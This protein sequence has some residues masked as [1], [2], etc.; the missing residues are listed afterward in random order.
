MEAELL[1][2]D[3]SADE[4]CAGSATAL[5]SVQKKSLGQKAYDRLLD[6]IITSE[7][8]A[9]SVLQDRA[10]SNLLNIS[11]TPARE[12][13][14]RLESEGFLARS[15]GRVL[16]VKEISVRDLIEILHIRRVLETESVTLATGRISPEILDSVAESIHA[17]LAKSHPTV[18]ED[19]TVDDRFHG[20]V[21]HHSGNSALAKM[22]QDL[23]MKTR[24]F[25]I[26]RV[27]E[28]FILGNREHLAMIE[29]LRRKDLD[30]ARAQ[31]QEHLDHVKESIVSKLCEI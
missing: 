22:I 31:I 16:I 27:P 29:S 11:R 17:L 8:P 28:R 1:D 15:P 13:L 26:N 21:A 10:I 12:A 9:G 24:I 25:N 23:R 4:D 7:I 20:M 19:W 3:V 5:L 6:M 2:D 14:F 18:S 30:R